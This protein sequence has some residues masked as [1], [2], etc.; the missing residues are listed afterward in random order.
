MKLLSTPWSS[1]KKK[2]NV[3]HAQIEFH[4]IMVPFY[5]FCLFMIELCHMNMNWP[6]C[7]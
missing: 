2:S 7:I 6:C 5:S 4:T 3:I 1:S